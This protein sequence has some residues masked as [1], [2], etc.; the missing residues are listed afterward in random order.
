MT[1]KFVLETELGR[2]ALVRRE[3]GGSSFLMLPPAEGFT[4]G[5]WIKPSPFDNT[6]PWEW[7]VTNMDVTIVTG[8]SSGYTRTKWG[9][10]RSVRRAL[11]FWKALGYQVVDEPGVVFDG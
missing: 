5:F 6:L 11:R 8:M 2:R 10:R 1:S 4:V 3:P 9:S 7:V